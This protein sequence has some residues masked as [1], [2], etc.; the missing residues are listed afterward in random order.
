MSTRP[1]IY[2]FL[3]IAVLAT[4]C[5]GKGIICSGSARDTVAAA[6]ALRGKLPKGGGISAPSIAYNGNYY[7]VEL[8]VTQSEEFEFNDVICSGTHSSSTEVEKDLNARLTA[9]NIDRVSAP[10]LV[11]NANH[12]RTE[13]CVSVKR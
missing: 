12:Y 7:K 5:L 13:G 4:D 6:N 1:S 9:A 10:A 3:F 2:A 11:Y 8:C